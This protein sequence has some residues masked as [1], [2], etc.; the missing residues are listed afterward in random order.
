MDTTQNNQSEANREVEP[1]Y[2]FEKY[3]EVRPGVV[4]K[5]HLRYDFNVLADFEQ[6]MGM[7][8]A[9]MMSNRATFGTARGLIWAGL[10]HEDRGLTIERVG[11]LM[12]DCIKNGDA[13]VTKFLEIA[14]KACNDQGALGPNVGLPALTEGAPAEKPVEGKV[15]PMPTTEG[16][17]ELIPVSKETL[18]VSPTENVTV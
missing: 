1:F 10:K 13:D 6:E 18:D 16:P 3:E 4:R 2:L 9:Q 15:I 7:G 12:G 8:F 5:R 17:I 11:K 14:L